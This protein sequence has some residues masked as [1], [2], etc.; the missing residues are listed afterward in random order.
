MNYGIGELASWLH[1]A[2]HQSVNSVVNLFLCTINASYINHIHIPMKF[3][4]IYDSAPIWN[5]SLN[6]RKKYII[7]NIIFIFHHFSFNFSFLIICCLIPTILH[8]A[9]I[10][11]DKKIARRMDKSDLKS[12]PITK[13]KLI[14]S[15]EAVPI[16]TAVGALQRSVDG[17]EMRAGGQKKR[18]SLT[19]PELLK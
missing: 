16:G 8:A 2:I 3:I 5:E 18:K 1:A 9:A 17:S 10:S 13:I 14:P 15:D 7:L 6:S 11:D 19:N 4:N 12:T